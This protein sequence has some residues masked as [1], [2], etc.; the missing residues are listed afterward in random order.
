MA[1]F[2]ARFGVVVTGGKGRGQGVKLDMNGLKARM[3]K[4]LGNREVL[5]RLFL[6]KKARRGV[7]ESFISSP[8]F[9]CVQH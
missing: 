1:K 4:L 9:D 6:I 5:E 8:S 3:S 2:G 7:G